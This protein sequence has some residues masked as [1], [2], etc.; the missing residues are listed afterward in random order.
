MT[1]GFYQKLLDR[2]WRRSGTL[3]Y[4]PNQKN[5]CCPHYT[6]R[7]DS[8]LF[9][10]TRDQRQTINRFNKYVTGDDYAKEAARLYPRSKQEAKRRDN[11]FNLVER[12][13][14]A[15]WKLL[16][17]PPEPAHD[18][19]VTLEE[20][21]FTEEKYEVYANYQR[22]VHREPPEKITTSGFRRFLCHSPLRREVKIGE[23]GKPMRFGSYH[24][25]YRLDGKLVAVGVLDLLPHCVSAVYFFYHEDIH[26]YNPGK[27]GALREIAL[28]LEG[29]YRYWYSGYYIHTC[30]KMRYKMDYSP[31]FV[32]DPETFTWDLV[33]K[34]V[35][36][37]FDKTPYLSLSRQ[38]KLLATQ[39]DNASDES[40]SSSGNTHN[41]QSGSDTPRDME[42]AKGEEDEDDDDADIYLLTSNMPGIPSLA[43]MREVDM[44][45]IL[46]RSDYAD[47]F[48]LTSDL[49]VWP[50]QDIANY[51]SIKSK[52]AEL[53]AVVGPDLTEEFCLDFRLRRKGST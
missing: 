4:R 47:S 14:E 41:V 23:N 53:V 49:V 18:F 48:F 20:D 2:C 38:R 43:Q 12:I 35:L 26:A 33:D 15:E 40:P 27:L 50:Q 9:K 36:A 3:L 10:P 52:V 45:S 28:A 5:A 51:P 37:L 22:V 25:C 21:K 42:I 34:E 44:D 7:L 30:P 16:K 29:G 39:G 46:V 1:P 32:L 8:T 6:L 13:H 24:Q 11:E 19:V 17:T 31:Q